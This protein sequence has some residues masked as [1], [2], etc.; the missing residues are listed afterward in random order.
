MCDGFMGISEQSQAFKLFSIHL[1]LQLISIQRKVSGK[2]K[3]IRMGLRNM[4]ATEEIVLY[5]LCM[6]LHPVQSKISSAGGI[7]Q[8]L[9]VI[10]FKRDGTGLFSFFSA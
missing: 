2:R 7:P 3:S 8:I 6:Q 4:F 1:T 10:P 5:S 9:L